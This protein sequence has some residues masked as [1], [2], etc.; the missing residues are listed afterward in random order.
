MM[1]FDGQG[2]LIDTID[3]PPAWNAIATYDAQRRQLWVYG[4]RDDE[5]T[6]FRIPIR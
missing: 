4:E 1:L 2:T 3:Q 5:A 6:L